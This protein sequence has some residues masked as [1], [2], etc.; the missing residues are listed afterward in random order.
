M[1]L[2]WLINHWFGPDNI[3]SITIGLRLKTVLT[4]CQEII[5]K[6]DDVPH[7]AQ[8]ESINICLHVDFLVIVLYR[9]DAVQ[10]D[11][12]IGMHLLYLKKNKNKYHIMFPQAA[13]QSSS[14]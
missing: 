5:T 10:W 13:A 8:N 9:E 4:E 1:P 2:I 6:L 11:A 7:G 12:R 3:L 14:I